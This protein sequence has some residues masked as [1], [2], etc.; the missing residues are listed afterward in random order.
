MTGEKDNVDMRDETQAR[1]IRLE[2]SQEHFG[3]Q[4][5]QLSLTV[6]HQ[7][8]NIEKSI[9]TLVN[10]FNSKGKISWPIMLSAG[11]LIL[12]LVT[13]GATGVTGYVALKTNPLEIKTAFIE[14][15]KDDIQELQIDNARM[16]VRVDSDEAAI[17]Y[18]W[19][20]LE[21]PEDSPPIIPVRR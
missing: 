13:F 16:K 20:K 9:A 14:D 6:T 1:I 8:G 5:D 12:S 3:K 11:M 19:Q 10:D 15:M 2:E 7:F 21:N 17:N 18:L 4:L